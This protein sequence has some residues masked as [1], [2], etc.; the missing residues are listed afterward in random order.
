MSNKTN[1]KQYWNCIR[2]ILLDTFEDKNIL[3]SFCLAIVFLVVGIISNICVPFTL[4][5]TVEHFSVSSDA[6]MTTF[7]LLSY[8]LIWMISQASLSIRALYTY[9]IEQRIIYTLG[10]KILSH[11]HTLSQSYFLNQKPGA[12]TNLIRRAQSDIPEVTLSIF[13][14]LVPTII[15]FLFVITLVSFIYPAIYGVFLAGTLIVFFGYTFVSMKSIFANRQIANEID[16]ETDGVVTDWLLNHEAIKVFYKQELAAHTCQKEL[17]KRENA[18]V[19]FV[20]SLN[21]VRLIQ[22]I[23]LGAGLSLLT[24]F[25]G[26]GVL[27]GT[28][29]VGD[30]V[31]FNGYILQFIIPISI[32]GQLA[33][34][35][36]KAL[37]DMRGI[38]DILLTEPEIKEHT[39]PVEIK[40]ECFQI[41]FKKVS[42]KY[43]DRVIIDNLSFKIGAGETLLI[44]GTTGAGKSTIAKLLLRLYD[45][46][47]G[48][49]LINQ[50]DTKLLSF[51]SLYETIGWVPQETYLLSD[52]LY[53]NLLFVKPEASLKE[54][55]FAL[56][57]ANLLSFVRK[58]PNGLH[59]N[60]GDR[61]AKLSGGE[62]QR[63]A[64]AR[65]F[66][67]KPNICIFD[68]ATSFLDNKTES[69][70]QENIEKYLPK[71]TK[72]IITHKP[73]MVNA[74]DKIIS[75]GHKRLGQSKPQPFKTVTNSLNQHNT[76]LFIG[77]KNENHW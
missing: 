39:H 55:E 23:I 13:F 12:L 54:M 6:S 27:A 66:L 19:N 9:R 61:G 32:L 76:N 36:K 62:K 2:S 1:Y 41:E 65:L 4:K 73:F 14:H 53:N 35:M 40:G 48:Q 47:D 50:T 7:I 43:Q 8:G 11:L 68:E 24:Y 56:D 28:L 33:Q 72:I 25:V 64:L 67:K 20:T 26:L 52:T 70:I 59:T 46:T 31:L 60:L 17:K 38:L 63:L 15:E 16:K 77:E 69:F 3:L 51:Q 75:L 34:D 42:F 71:M 44:M 18:E 22:S 49:I 45:P 5:R 58:L 21:T 37:L 30:F 29:T 10:V 74:A 57:K